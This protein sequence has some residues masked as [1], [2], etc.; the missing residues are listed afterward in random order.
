MVPLVSYGTVV[1]W[2]RSS[3]HCQYEGVVL[4]ITMCNIGG[5]ERMEELMSVTEYLTKN[6]GRGHHW[7]IS[8]ADSH[9]SHG[10]EKHET[11]KVHLRGR[12]QTS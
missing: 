3:S 11:Q 1:V 6:T 4:R 10:F 7:R 8:V 5:M 9:L 2:F 12:P